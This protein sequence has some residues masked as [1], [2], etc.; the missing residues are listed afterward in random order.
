MKIP[1]LGQKWFAFCIRCEQIN[2]N[3][4]CRCP[5]VTVWSH[6]NI[7]RKLLHWTFTN[8]I[9]GKLRLSH[10]RLLVQQ[11][12]ALFAGC[13]AGSL[14]LNKCL[15]NCWMKWK[16]KLIKIE[17]TAE[18]FT[19]AIKNII[20]SLLRQ[21]L[22]YQQFNTFKLSYANSVKLMSIKLMRR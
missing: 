1:H 2:A 8:I 10:R 14:I 5:L 6:L 20:G 3:W 4:L 11:L 16:I 13:F 15:R 7:R 12:V 21:R 22:L 17:P 9:I 19:G 18:K